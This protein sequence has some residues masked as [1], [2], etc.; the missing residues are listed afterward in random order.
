MNY[1]FYRRSAPGVALTEALDEL[2]RGGQITP[3]LAM[4]V[5][6]QF[7]RSISE[8][9][10]AVR[11]KCVIKGHLSSYR[12][13]DDV[14]TFIVRNAELKFDDDVRTSPLLKIVACNARKP[15]NPTAS[16]GSGASAPTKKK[17]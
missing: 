1:E 7:D 8:A 10:G 17:S 11:G 12:Y 4:R 3:Q 2:V 6:F 15:E 16:V 9:L 13:L 14:W 5:L